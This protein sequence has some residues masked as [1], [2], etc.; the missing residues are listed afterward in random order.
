MA[1]GI[2]GHTVEF[3]SERLLSLIEI[4]FQRPFFEQVLEAGFLAVGP[5]PIGNINA[6][7]GCDDAVQFRPVSPAYSKIPC[8]RLV[9]GRSAK[10]NAE[11]D[12]AAHVHRL[13]ADASFVLLDHVPMEGRRRRIRDV[14]RT[15][16]AD[17][18]RNGR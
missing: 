9:A 14:L 7:H 1:A 13:R 4:L 3:V 8:K 5:V 16:S 12:F 15:F 2:E 6:D 11:E 18:K 17:R 10:R